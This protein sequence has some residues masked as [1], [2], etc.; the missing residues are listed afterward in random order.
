MVPTIRVYKQ[1]P[2]NTVLIFDTRGDIYNGETGEKRTINFLSKHC[3]QREK[4]NNSFYQ[5]RYLMETVDEV[6]EMMKKG[7]TCCLGYSFLGKQFRI[8]NPMS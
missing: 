2:K 1:V 8:F 6:S 5:L 3:C 7:L 4:Q